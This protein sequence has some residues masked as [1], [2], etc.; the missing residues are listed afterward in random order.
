MGKSEEVGPFAF[1]ISA[2]KIRD[3]RQIA[4]RFGS[5]TC[6]QWGTGV[7]FLEQTLLLVVNEVPFTLNTKISDKIC[8]G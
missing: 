2:D 8:M 1:E 7:L 4:A 6:I 3:K 5:S